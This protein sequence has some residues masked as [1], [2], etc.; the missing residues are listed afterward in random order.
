MKNHLLGFAGV[1]LQIIALAQSEMC[2][3]SSGIVDELIEGTT[4]YESS[5][6]F[7]KT[8]PVCNARKSDAQM[9]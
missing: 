3:N 7:S 1:E 5:A 6:Y 4:K 8:L 2:W 9:T